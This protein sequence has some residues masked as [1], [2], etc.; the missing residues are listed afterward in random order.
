VQGFTN[1]VVARCVHDW[2]SIGAKL[3]SEYRSGQVIASSDHIEVELLPCV[4]GCL[5]TLESGIIY[6]VHNCLAFT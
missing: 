1:G 6:W 4:F 2:E 5:V 3:N